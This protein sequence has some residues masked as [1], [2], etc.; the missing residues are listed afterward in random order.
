M[1]IA[2]PLFVSLGLL[3]TMSSLSIGLAVALPAG[4]QLPLHFALW[5]EPGTFTSAGF[6][7]SLLPGAAALAT[8]LF[9]LGPKINKGIAA[10]Q[11]RYLALWLFTV[12][13]LAVAHGFIIRGALYALKASMS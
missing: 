1:P 13:I 9:A 7:L 8:L 4:T 5:A 6:A 11:G 12:F 2:L 3:I 10:I